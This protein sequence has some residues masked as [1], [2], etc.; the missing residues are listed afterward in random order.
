MPAAD[1][2]ECDGVGFEEEVEDAVDEG[3]VEGD[4]EEDGFE[5]EHLERAEDVFE[6]DVFE[7]G[8]AFVQERVQGPVVRF[9]AETSCA[10]LEDNGC[11]ALL[12][13]EQGDEAE[14]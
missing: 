13:D 2:L 9:P 4:E 1:F 6:D 3:E 14:E 12:N 8:F 5:D 7:G 11:I 10:F